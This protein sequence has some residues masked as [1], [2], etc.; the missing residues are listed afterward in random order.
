MVAYQALVL[1]QNGST[2]SAT[3]QTKLTPDLGKDGV[4]VKVAYSDINYKDRLTMNPQ[5]GVLRHYPITPGIDFAGIVVESDN[6]FFEAGD[7]VLCTG[8]ATG[9]KIDGGYAEYVKVPSEWLFKLPEGLTLA[10]A[11]QFGTA[12]FTAAIALTKLLR[13]AFTADHTTP[14]L[15]TGAT[16]GVGSFALTMLA[17]LGFTNL[18]A[19]TRDLHQQAY[20]KQLGA[21]Q[22]INTADLIATPPKVLDHQAF[23][24]VI[25]TLGGP[26]LAQ[27]LP[28]IQSGGLVATCGNIAGAT[29]NTTVMPFILRGITLAG[30]DSVTY[31]RK[32]RK[33]LWQ[34]LATTFKPQTW[35]TTTLIAFTDLAQELTTNTHQV[36]RCLIAF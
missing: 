35:P 1:E 34:L 26:V 12:G 5:S 36:G 9:I 28:Q 33:E 19:T 3:Y 6:L 32:D 10:E 27:I 2:V 13:Q 31:P 7:Q 14:L 17:Q 8:Y 4:L 25:D 29:L 20:L 15:I 24:G 30:I 11:M 18:T 21:T 23:S 16:G 22:I